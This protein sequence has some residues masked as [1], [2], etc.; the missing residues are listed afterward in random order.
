[1][2][3]VRRE[4]ETLHIGEDWRRAYTINNDVDLSGASAVCKV[5]TKQGKLLCEASTT[6]VGKTIMVTISKDVTIG[7]GKVYQKAEYDVFLIAGDVTYK[8]IMG[9]LNIIHDVSMH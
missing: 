4:N 8:L 9:D 2:D 6:I 3:L 5:R 7:I 1:M